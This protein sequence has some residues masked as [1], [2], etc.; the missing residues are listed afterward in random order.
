MK[1]LISIMLSV[2]LL[3]AMFTVSVYAD[4]LL[5]K[6]VGNYQ[7]PGSGTINDG[8]TDSQ[9]ANGQSSTGTV[10]LTLSGVE[11]RYAVDVEFSALEFTLSGNNVWNVNELQY[12]IG[13]TSNPEIDI[14]VRVTNYSDM[15][16]D[17]KVEPVLA[18]NL[19][20]IGA[21]FVVTDVTGSL[22]GNISGHVYTSTLPSASLSN[23]ATTDSCKV[24]FEP[25]VEQGN[26]WGL[27]FDNLSQFVIDG[28][29]TLG[30][31][32]VT[33]SKNVTNSTN[34]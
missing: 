30:T 12:D 10:T 24:E 15:P 22:T 6:P 8:W 9:F 31:I 26:D 7:G 11:H 23:T 28:K 27:L 13:S 21:R 5:Y 16:I 33:V 32:T 17:M 18:S 2:A 3:V 14:V 34:V 25:T 29:V 19:S 1:K 4:E 20:G